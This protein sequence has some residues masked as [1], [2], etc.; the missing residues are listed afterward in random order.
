VSRLVAEEVKV[1]SMSRVLL[2]DGDVMLYQNCTVVEVAFDWGDDIWTLHS[3]AR[4]AKHLTDN[5]LAALKEDLNADKIEVAFSD[6]KN[7]RKM[8]LPTYKYHRKSS[9]KPLAFHA[10]K[11][12]VSEVYKSTVMP[13]LEADD[14]LGIWATDPKRK[15]EQ[16][17]VTIDKDLLTIPGL[18][19]NPTKPDQ[20]VIEIDDRTATYNHLYQTLTGDSVDGYKGCPGIGPVT[21]GRLLKKDQSWDTVLEAYSSAG[22]EAEDALV[23]ARV[24]RILHWE[25]YDQKAQEVIEWQ[26]Y[27]EA[28]C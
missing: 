4:A 22:L 16:I 25:D 20:G 24:A 6:K 5:W 2:I 10:V 27:Q 21:A 9:R 26:P 18:H 28:N 12:Y 23:Q 17:V 11:E 8:I 19:Y 7:F 15:D 1:T 3:D 14:V 13:W